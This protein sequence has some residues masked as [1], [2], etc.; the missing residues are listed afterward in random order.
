[1]LISAVSKNAVYGLWVEYTAS[2]S[3]KKI[4]VGLH[5]FLKLNEILDKGFTFEST[6]TRASVLD[7]IMVFHTLAYDY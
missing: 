7:K 5:D 2:A 3:R 1:M 4:T 6:K